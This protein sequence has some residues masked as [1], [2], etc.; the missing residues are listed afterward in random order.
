MAESKSRPPE[1]SIAR[2][3]AIREKTQSTADSDAVRRGLRL[4]ESLIA[5]EGKESSAPSTG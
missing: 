3:S 2:I 4:Y 5:A 1:S